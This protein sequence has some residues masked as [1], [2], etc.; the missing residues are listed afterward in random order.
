[1]SYSLRRASL[2]LFT[3]ALVAPNMALA[4][5]AEP[6]PA[7]TEQAASADQQAEPVVAATLDA[8]TVYKT[9]KH[10]RTLRNAL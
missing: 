7:E 4:Q 8:K 10:F 6:T 5:T 1:M 3:T 2:L 9:S